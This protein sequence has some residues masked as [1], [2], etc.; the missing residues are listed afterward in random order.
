VKT[1]IAM[2]IRASVAEIESICDNCERTL[3]NGES[4]AKRDMKPFV[5]GIRAIRSLA[6][7][8]A[9]VAIW[10]T[11]TAFFGLAYF[12]SGR[13]VRVEEAIVFT[14]AFAGAAAVSAVIALAIGSKRR[15]ALEAALPMVILIAAP[16][17]IAGALTWLA[18]TIG[19]LNAVDYFPAV[20]YLPQYGGRI[21]AAVLGVAR[22]TIP[23]GVILGAGIGAIA[24]V[25]ILLARHRPRL[26]AWSVV[27]LLLL[28]VIGS[29]HVAAFDRVVDLVM[30]TRLEGV[31]RLMVSWTIRSELAS[32]IGA[33][34]GA[35]VG[36][37]VAYGA[38]R[39]SDRS[40]A[41]ARSRGHRH[42]E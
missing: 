42:V 32:A 33:T 10:M 15:W 12:L 8:L 7:P 23:T 19:S 34:A 38:A 17:G 39:L 30:K 14:I 6:R 37:V 13:R 22:Q 9:M 41:S 21:P 16:V 5:G 3:G 31:N 36:A 29:V 24:G 11:A 18:P 2:M 25:S 35:F 28:C 20:D 40:Q 27:G 4:V 26:V 1:L